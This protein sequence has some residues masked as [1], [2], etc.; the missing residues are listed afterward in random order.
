M[1]AWEEVLVRWTG[2]FSKSDGLGPEHRPVL[3]FRARSRDSLPPELRTAAV[4]GVRKAHHNTMPFSN[5]ARTMNEN[6]HREMVLPKWW[7][8]GKRNPAL[9]PPQRPSGSASVEGAHENTGSDASPA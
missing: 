7:K 4:V 2:G 6:L 1:F 8:E 5:L 9:Q 3:P